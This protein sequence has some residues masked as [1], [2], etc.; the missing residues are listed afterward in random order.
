LQSQGLGAVIKIVHVYKDIY[1]PI[2]GGIER[3][4]DSIRRALPDVEQDVLACSRQVRTI[5]RRAPGRGTDVLIGELGRVLSTPL[6]PSFPVWL[7]RIAQDAIV[8]L[9]MPQPIGE[10][11]ALT[12]PEDVPIVVTYHADIYRQRWLLFLYRPLILKCLRK[13]NAVIAGSESL[14]RRSPLLVQSG[15]PI[16]VVPYAIDVEKWAPEH[17]NRSLVEEIRERYGE[18]HLLAVGRLV[19]YKGFDRLVAAAERLAWPVVIVGEG[20]LRRQLENEIASR[21]VADRIHLVGQVDDERLA[22]HFAAASA[23]VLPSWNHA[24]AFG[25]ATLE[26]QAAELPVIVTDVGT[27][28]TEAFLPGETGFAIPPNSITALTAA[29]AELA[30]DLEGSLEMGR[31][32]RRYVTEHHSLRILGT[33][34]RHVYDRVSAEPADPSTAHLPELVV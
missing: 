22:A 19:P 32:G 20:V 27:G 4:I 10:L 26:A 23:F 17:A 9:H 16:D 25:I 8:H 18:R 11:S 15:V 31:R 3:H 30:A 33:S 5:V 1:P 24:E 29:V 7:H 6:A 28:T 21:G 34:L 14:R 13:A 2:M 12:L